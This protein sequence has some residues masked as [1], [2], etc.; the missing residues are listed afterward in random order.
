MRPFR[1][2]SALCS[3]QGPR[4]PSEKRVDFI[5]TLQ[6]CECLMFHTGPQ[7]S[8]R[9]QGALE[10]TPIFGSKNAIM[11]AEVARP[12]RNAQFKTSI[13]RDIGKYVKP[14]KKKKT[15]KN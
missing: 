2:A 8:N 15:I 10:W 4:G 11:H 3:T 7:K 14:S 13:T 9:N 5:E 12:I 6:K 1:N